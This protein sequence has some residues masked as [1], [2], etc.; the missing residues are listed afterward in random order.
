[1]SRKLKLKVDSLRVQS[2]A[3][4]GNAPARG[5]VRGHWSYGCADQTGYYFP[6]CG[7]SC[8]NK[9]AETPQYSFCGCG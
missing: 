9:C 4:G 6:S 7:E 2:F 5:T 8:I 1:M 3:A